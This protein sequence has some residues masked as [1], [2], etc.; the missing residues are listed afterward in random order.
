MRWLLSL[1]AV[2]LFS[3]TGYAQAAPCQ[4]TTDASVNVRAQPDTNAAVL[5][6]IIPGNPASVVGAQEGWY[7][8][9]RSDFGTGWVSAAVV[10]L[11]GDCAAFETSINPFILPFDLSDI[12]LLFTVTADGGKLYGLNL[13]TGATRP[14]TTT[15]IGMPQW[16]PDG[17]A[18]VFTL[19]RSAGSSDLF[20]MNRDASVVR[21]LT[22]DGK[23]N[24]QPI[25]S[26]DG[27]SIA[28]WSRRDAPALIQRPFSTT[29][30][31]YIYV[32]QPNGSVVRRVIPPPEQPPPWYAA[33][34][35]L[36]GWTRDG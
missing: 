7:Q 24:V 12:D 15:Q 19:S 11:V 32:M 6:L 14:L 5:A 30:F 26:P 23:F 9:Q 35:L 13:A 29:N 34:E 28:F 20:W 31:T 4:A 3:V 8:V 18:A 2:S 27:A 21:P 1:L 16:T 25:W 17:S 33:T 10:H 36:Q 22:R